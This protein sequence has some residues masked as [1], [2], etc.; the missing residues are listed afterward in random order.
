MIDKHELKS[1]KQYWRLEGLISIS[2][3]M[4]QSPSQ[5]TA[6]DQS[7]SKSSSVTVDCLSAV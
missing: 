2:E 6:R 1:I 4:E 7:K 3:K 5:L